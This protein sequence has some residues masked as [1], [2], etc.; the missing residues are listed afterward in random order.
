MAIKSGSRGVVVKDIITPKGTIYKN[1]KIKI[2]EI[3]ELSKIRVS[4]VAGRIFWVK[5]SDILIK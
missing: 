2:E 5:Q 3:R 4:D 1:T